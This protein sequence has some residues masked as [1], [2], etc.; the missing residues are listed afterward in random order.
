[1]A[2]YGQ[3]MTLAGPL[4]PKGQRFR[5]AVI[6]PKYGL[7]G[8]GE[9][10]ASEVTERIAR[11]GRFDVHVFANKWVA[12]PGS[13]VTFHKVPIARFPRF[14]RPLSFAAFAGRMVKKGGFDLVHSHERTSGADIYSVHCVPHAFWVRDVRQKRPSLFDK[15]VVSAEKQMISSGASSVFL[16]V[17]S[18]AMD[19]FRSEYKILPGKWRPLHPGV[20][21]E[22]F[23]SPPVEACRAE[24]RAR[25]GIR[26]EDFLVL[27]VGMNFEV[28]GLDTV[29]RALSI[30]KSSAPGAS[31]RLLVVGRGNERK[32]SEMAAAHGVGDSVVF[33][34]TRSKGLERYYRAADCFAMLSSFDTFGMVVLEAMAAGLPVI[35]SSGVGA[36]DLVEEGVNGF[37]LAEREDSKAAA[38]MLSALLDPGRRH[39]MGSAASL[40]ASAH[41][42]DILAGRMLELYMDALSAKGKCFVSAQH[43]A[44][45]SVLQY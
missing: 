37:V 6:I 20:D 36:K 4:A 13:P 39:A 21:F 22:R 26:E 25:H 10:F 17:S 27:F 43:H 7:V 41:G 16:P 44:A 12:E 31:I 23:S 42:W 34:G 35:I 15:A 9:R 2:A 3:A 28:K 5:V 40:T 11:D 33:A 18:I 29:I 30:A 45:E 14:L 8:G 24:I 38:G 1:M 19:A 32:Y